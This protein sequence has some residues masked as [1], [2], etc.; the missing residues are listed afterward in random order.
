MELFKSEYIFEGSA[1]P[2]K[3]KT[4]ENKYIFVFHLF[5]KQ[6]ATHSVRDCGVG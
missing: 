1:F 3:G 5:N 2:V 6:A 4:C